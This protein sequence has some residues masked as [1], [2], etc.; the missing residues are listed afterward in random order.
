MEITYVYGN[1]LVIHFETVGTF[2]KWKSSHK[3]KSC[4]IRLT[5]NTSQ[6]FCKTHYFV[7]LSRITFFLLF[8]Q[9]TTKL[10]W[11]TTLQQPY[12]NC[13]APTMWTLTKK[14]REIWTFFWTKKDSNFLNIK[15]KVFKREYKNAASRL[16]QNFL[17]GEADF[18]QF[19]RQRNQLVVAADNFLREQNLSPVLQPTL[20]KDME[21]QL[22]LVHKVIV[23]V[24]CPNRRIF[25]TLLRYKA[26]KPETSCARVRL[27]GLKKK[28]EK[29]Q[30]NVYVN[31]K[32]DQFV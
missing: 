5:I 10:E 21:E 32:L 24:H 19:N 18:N 13:L 9:T 17:I 3:R 14:T 20:S 30:Q 8:L 28:E 26:D 16:R 29:I 22:N 12:A 4:L 2:H 7:L 23:V 11:P 27:F 15:L 25:V 6:F 31:Y 1:V